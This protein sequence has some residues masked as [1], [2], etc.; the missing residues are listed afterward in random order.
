MKIK[1]FEKVTRTLNKEVSAIIDTWDRS[2]ISPYEFEESIPIGE[3]AYL[4]LTGVRAWVVDLSES[5]GDFAQGIAHYFSDDLF[6]Q[7]ATNNFKYVIIIEQGNQNK[8][9]A[10]FYTSEMGSYGVSLIKT[11]SIDTA[12]EWLK[13]F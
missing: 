12:I 3:L 8:I 9:S 5:Q 6:L 1:I 4:Q 2:Q 10:D 13:Y 7:L 11:N